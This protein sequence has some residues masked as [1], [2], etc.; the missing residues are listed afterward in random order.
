MCG[1]GT[2]SKQRQFHKEISKQDQFYNEMKE[3]G[4]LVLKQNGTPHDTKQLWNLV[5]NLAKRAVALRKSAGRKTGEEA[6]TKHMN[7]Q[8]PT[9]LC[10]EKKEPP[11]SNQQPRGM[12]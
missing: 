5:R 1:L 11:P 7:T 8:F 2:R 12:I 4:F 6:L 3:R 10:L 9:L